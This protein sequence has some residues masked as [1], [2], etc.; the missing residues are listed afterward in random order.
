A[1]KQA[2]DTLLYAV[3]GIV[4]AILAYAIVNFVAGALKSNSSTPPPAA[5]PPGLT[6]TASPGPAPALTG[7]SGP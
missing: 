3:I 1:V 7:T 4:V 6:G 2:K 5:S